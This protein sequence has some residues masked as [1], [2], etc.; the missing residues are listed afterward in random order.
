MAV[1]ATMLVLAPTTVPAAAAPLTDVTISGGHGNYL[2][3]WAP[4]RAD[5]EDP[6]NFGPAGTVT[7]DNTISLKPFTTDLTPAYLSDVD[8]MYDG[9]VNDGDWGVGELD[10]LLDWIDDGGVA[11]V[12][13]DADYADELSTALGAPV[14]SRCCDVGT[15]TPL[16]ADHPIVD[17]PFGAWTEIQNLG[18]VGHFGT[19]LSVEWTPVAQDEF[20]N[21]AIAVRD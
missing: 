2:L 3:D 10:A 7:L 12:T 19:S 9:W 21:I 17:G 5:V 6:S 14:T 1:F 18:T 4:S 11:I 15:M 13:E 8:I 16:V 20:G